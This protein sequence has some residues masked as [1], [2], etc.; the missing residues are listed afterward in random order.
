M[1][2][3][4]HSEAALAAEQDARVRDA[5]AAD[6][7]LTTVLEEKAIHEAEVTTGVQTETV[8]P[9]DA[10]ACGACALSDDYCRDET[11]ASAVLAA[12]VNVKARQGVMDQDADDHLQAY[13]DQLRQITTAYLK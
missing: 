4:Q 2:R 5:A 6:A 7:K 11:I 10:R 12:A 3:L 9:V 8:S 1:G 13:E